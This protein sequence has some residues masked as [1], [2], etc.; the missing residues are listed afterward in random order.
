LIP[1]PLYTSGGRLPLIAAATSPT[2]CLFEPET[3]T[4]VLASTSILMPSG[5][6][7][8]TGC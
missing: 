7:A 8:L 5:A 3:L 4:F 1:L 6:S 2:N